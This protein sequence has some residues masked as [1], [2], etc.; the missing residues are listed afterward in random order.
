M[1]VVLVEDNLI[2]LGTDINSNWEFKDGDLTLVDNEE[3]IIQSIVNRLNC[4]YDSLD[5]YYFEYGSSLSSFLGFPNT[6]ETLE[7]I[8]IEI[9]STLQQDP[10]LHSFDIEAFYI[11]TGEIGI[12]IHIV[13]NEEDDMSLSLVIGEDGSINLNE[14]GGIIGS[15]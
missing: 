15:E 4:E 12:N 6:P 9:E 14:D 13:F 5:L 2:E 8:K 11:D 1:K 3:N 10:R 7:F